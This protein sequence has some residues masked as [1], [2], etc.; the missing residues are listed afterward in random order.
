MCIPSRSLDGGDPQTPL[1]RGQ[2]PSYSPWCL[3][4]QINRLQIWCLRHQKIYVYRCIFFFC[5]YK[6]IHVYIQKK[7]IHIYTYIC[8]FKK[9]IYIHGRLSNTIVFFLILF[10]F[11]ILP[12]N[13]TKVNIAK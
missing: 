10:I 3:W 9:N 1:R 12:L 6:N 13:K 11:P 2:A 7:N 8:I 4:H 5:I